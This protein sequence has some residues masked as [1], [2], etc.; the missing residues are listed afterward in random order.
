MLSGRGSLERA[1][2]FDFL[3]LLLGLFILGYFW[4]SGFWLRRVAS[5]GE[6]VA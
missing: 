1:P 4:F 6:K 5:W 2:K 3:A